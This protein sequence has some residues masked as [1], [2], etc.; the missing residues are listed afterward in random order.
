M[1]EFQTITTRLSQGDSELLGRL[2]EQSS[3]AFEQLVETFQGPV[4]GFIYRLLED[5]SEA[6]DVTQE[7]FLKV[8]RKL[9]EFRG[10]CSLKTWIYRIAIHEASNRRRWFFRHRQRE[11]PMENEREEDGSHWENIVDQRDTP[12]EALHRRE[13][14]ELITEA[15]RS[16]DSRMRV[17]L[18]LRDIEGLS[19]NEIADTLQI[20]LGT[21]KSRILRAREALK[22][23][24]RRQAPEL[25]PD[26]C[27]LQTE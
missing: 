11:K 16:M 18:V 7:V 27:A 4:F 19:Y 20:S 12:Y 17:A 22:T 23:R 15:L 6:P 14:M 24:L 13:Q 26:H 8:F 10:E 21:V 3:E 2:R 1:P 9:D 25:A 5:P